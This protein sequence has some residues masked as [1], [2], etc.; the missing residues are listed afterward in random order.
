MLKQVFP[1]IEDHGLGEVVGNVSSEIS[2]DR[3]KKE[4]QDGKAHELIETQ[5]DLAGFP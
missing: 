2:D 1:N 4:K 3:I 5:P